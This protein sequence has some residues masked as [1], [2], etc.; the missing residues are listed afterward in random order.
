MASLFEVDQ[1]AL[2]SLIT[3]VNTYAQDFQT[4]ENQLTPAYTNFDSGFMSP[5]KPQLEQTWSDVQSLAKQVTSKIQ[6]VQTGL[7]NLQQQVQVV[8]QVTF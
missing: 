6:E 3:L 8:E 1:D 2:Q 7:Q 4:L 5:Q